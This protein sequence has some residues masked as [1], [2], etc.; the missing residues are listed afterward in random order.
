MEKLGYLLVPFIVGTLI[1]AVVSAV[2]SYFIIHKIAS[3]YKPV[4]VENK[5]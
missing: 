5:Q 1:I 3:K 4:I 2:I